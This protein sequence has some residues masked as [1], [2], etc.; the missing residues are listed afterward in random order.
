MNPSIEFRVA[1]LAS[2][3]GVEF[4]P[5]EPT[6]LRL[7]KTFDA[8]R[9]QG[10]VLLVKWDG[11]RQPHLGDNGQYTALITGPPL[12]DDEVF[13]RKDDSSM[14]AAMQAV[15]AGYHDWLQGRTG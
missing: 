7:L 1:S 15:L 11:E 3:L 5:D 9:E 10:L 13:F 14:E 4:S 6:L 12:A 2:D 8:L